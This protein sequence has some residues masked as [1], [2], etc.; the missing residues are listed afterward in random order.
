VLTEE[1]GVEVVFDAPEVGV[2]RAAAG[3]A[4]GTSL[5]GA[6]PRGAVSET[7]PDEASRAE[8]GT[9][10][11]VAFAVRDSPTEASPSATSPLEAASRSLTEARF[12]PHKSPSCFPFRS[13]CG[14]PSSAPAVGGV[15]LSF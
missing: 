7:A 12:A 1:V 2:A 11:E 13:L 3:V 14:A 10:V 9:T 5:P 4:A 6:S 8:G 15:G